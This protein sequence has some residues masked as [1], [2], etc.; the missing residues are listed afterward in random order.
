MFKCTKTKNLYLKKIL[1]FNIA[2]HALSLSFA[3]LP[4]KFRKKFLGHEI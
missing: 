3:V 1:V 2:I 4:A